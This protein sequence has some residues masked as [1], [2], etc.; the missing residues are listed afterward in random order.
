MK[1]PD[2]SL[3]VCGT[4]AH[5]KCYSHH[6]VLLLMSVMGVGMQQCMIENQNEMHKLSISQEWTQICS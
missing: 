4:P 1:F 5:V 3:M 6:A 2:I